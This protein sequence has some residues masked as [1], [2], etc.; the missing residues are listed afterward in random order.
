MDAELPVFSDQQFEY[1]RVNEFE[2]FHNME[3]EIADKIIKND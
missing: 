1:V 3:K 2:N